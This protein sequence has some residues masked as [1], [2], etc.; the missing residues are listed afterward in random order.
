[1]NNYISDSVNFLPSMEGILLEPNGMYFCFLKE[2]DIVDQ[3]NVG[4]KLWNQMH[5][6]LTLV[7]CISGGFYIKNSG[8]NT[9]L[10]RVRK[11]KNNN[12]AI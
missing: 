1:M 10:I 11:I 9:V 3:K 2:Q 4:D 8:N 6:Y 7:K 12:I 5:G